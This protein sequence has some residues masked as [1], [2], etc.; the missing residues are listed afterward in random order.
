MLPQK[1]FIRTVCRTQN[2]GSALEKV[3]KLGVETIVSPAISKRV[4]NLILRGSRTRRPGGG[5]GRRQIGG[6]GSSISLK[7]I[8]F[9]NYYNPG[10]SYATNTG[11]IYGNNLMF[12][13]A[14]AFRLELKIGK[15]IN[16]KGSQRFSLIILFN[17]GLYFYVLGA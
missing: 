16:K 3:S 5:V 14:I 7:I 11:L 10:F 12:I 6:V 9:Y 8:P 4:S 2:A 17:Y 1:S 15:I 13:C